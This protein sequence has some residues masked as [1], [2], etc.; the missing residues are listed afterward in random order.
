MFDK[1]LF[2]ELRNMK[3]YYIIGTAASIVA[4]SLTIGQALILS[5]IISEVFIKKSL[6]AT[7]KRSLFLL[8]LI[9]A[10]KA[11]ISGGLEYFNRKSAIEIKSRLRKRLIKAL[12]LEGPIKLRNESNGRLVSMVEEGVE[13][14]DAYYSEFIPQLIMIMI[15]IPMI[16]YF[17][18]RRDLLSGIIMFFTAPLI[19]VFMI[20]IGKMAQ[21]FNDTQWKS[22]QKMSGHF[23]DILKGLSTLKLFGKSKAQREVI[24]KV[25]EN[26]S[27]SIMGVLKISFLSALVLEL[28]ATIS[29]AILAVTLGIRLLYGKI[30]FDA[31][32]FILLMAPEYYQPLR[33]LGA[34]FHAAM[35]AKSAADNIFP[36]LDGVEGKDILDE[37]NKKV[38]I[39]FENIKID[40]DELEFSYNGDKKVICNMNMNI[41]ANEKIA[42]VGASGGGKSTLIAIIMGFLKDY[43]GS[44]AIN[45]VQLRSIELEAWANNFAYVPQHPKIYKGTILENLSVAAPGTKVEEVLT[46]AKKIGIDTFVS[47]LPKGYNTLVG[48]GG[49]ALSGGQIQLIAIGRAY[50][51]CTG[52]VILDE[53]T[54]ALDID[55]EKMI[56]SAL[57]SI[58]EGRTVITIAHRIPT[59]INSD[60][61]YVI[62]E[63]KIIEKGRH[64][65]LIK[66]NG[67]YSKLLAMGEENI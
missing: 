66:N 59:I 13:A 14:F 12:I 17:V 32:F 38:K 34:K 25:S 16:L 30:Y 7:V 42:L 26:F 33:G 40:I 18:S 43:S 41:V 5:N 48:E 49:I 2:K 50:L 45:G 51:K 28:I 9:I 3:Q 62:E 21:Y 37:N 27:E 24:W 29:T 63:G 23:L 57:D 44:I 47:S 60:T 19:P 22:M 11:I 46:I 52:L 35:S 36:I 54:S 64:E 10:L 20:L 31:A 56:G 67:L 8:L 39:K 65:E 6:F 61:I 15:S 58:S 55:S 1:R 53:P 4:V